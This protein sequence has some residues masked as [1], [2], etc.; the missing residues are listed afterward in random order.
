[1][2]ALMYP[3]LI[4]SLELAVG[5]VTPVLRNVLY[6]VLDEF[7]A[8]VSTTIAR[9]FVVVL[10]IR[11]LTSTNA[12]CI[13]ATLQLNSVGNCSKPRFNVEPRGR[14]DHQQR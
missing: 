7:G 3:V 13:A 9:E 14:C 8:V 4:A 5:I 6:K 12:S 10:W 11:N 2:K 1:M